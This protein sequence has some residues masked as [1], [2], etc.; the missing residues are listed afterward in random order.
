MQDVAIP[1]LLVVGNEVW[2]GYGLIL[3]LIGYGIVLWHAPSRAKAMAHVASQLGMHFEPIMSRAQLGIK[4]TTFD[5]G[6]PGENCM[7][8]MIAGRETLIFD[9][10][11]LIEPVGRP[12]DDNPTTE[13]TIVG[14]HV[15]PDTTCR[16]RGILQPSDWHVEKLGE[17]VF[18]YG[19]TG[20]IKPRKILA[21]VEE[22][23]GWLNKSIDPKGVNPTLPTDGVK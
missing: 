20:L 1:A 15:S 14:F 12:A 6:Y 4:G 10:T 11:M 5:V 22:A 2:I 13:Q 19:K 23:R 3:I 8:G 16:D 7:R 21:Y 17:W 18:V 9:K